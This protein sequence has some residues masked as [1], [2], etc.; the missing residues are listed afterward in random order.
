MCCLLCFLLSVITGYWYLT[1]SNRVQRMCEAYLS[2][3]TGGRVEVR[4]AALSIFEGLRLDGVSIRVDKGADAFDST[5]LEVQTVLIKYNPESI[6][7]GKL[8]ATQ[9]VAIDP[10]V[11]LV[12]NLDARRWNYQ[13]MALP[14]QPSSQPNELRIA[15]L[16][17][18]LL[19]NGQV[20]YSQIQDGVMSEL[21]TMALDGSVSPGE[22][23]GTCIFRLQSRMESE[24][25]GPVVQG[26]MV[27]A[28]GEVTAR[29]E[30]FEFGLGIKRMLPYVVRQFLEDHQL[31][32]RI[33]V[34][35]LHVQ[36]GRGGARPIF[37][38]EMN[39]NKVGMAVSP[40]EWLSRLER[41][42][43]QT[44]QGAF[45]LMRLG[46]M[47]KG[48]AFGVRG[49]GKERQVDRP[50]RLATGSKAGVVAVADASDGVY[51]NPEPRTPNPGFVDRLEGMVTPQLI[52]LEKVDGRFVFTQDGVEVHD[53][54]GWVERNSFRIS[55][56]MDGYTGDGAASLEITGDDV[57]IPHSPRYVNAMPRVVREVYEALH[58]E[59]TGR[60]WVKIDRPEPGQKPI[61]S[62]ALEVLEGQFA[63][64]LFPYPLRN[65][66]GKI[67]FGPD[68]D[69][70]ERLDIINIRGYGVKGGPNED[71]T[72]IVNGTVAPIS[73]DADVRIHVAGEHILSEPAIRSALP[74]DAR[75]ALKFLD[76]SGR[77][78]YPTFRAN[79]GADITR[80]PGPYKPFR[81]K[82]TMDLEDAAGA[83]TGFP[84]PLDHI[85]GR[86]VIGEN[87][88][89][90]E[91]WQSKKADASVTLDGSVTWGH[92]RPV[93]PD[94]TI[95]ARNAPID[96][97]L[98][99]AIAS[100]QR[101]WLERLGVSGKL[102]VDGKIFRKQSSEF[103][104]QSSANAP[105]PR[106]EAA[107]DA[108]SSSSSNDDIAVALDMRVHDGG[109]WPRDT[110]F[111]V[112]DVSGKVRLSDG[113]VTL[114]DFKGKRGDGTL[115]GG[116]SVLWKDGKPEL[117]VAGSAKDLLMEHALY[118]LLPKDAQ[119]AW[120]AVQPQGT[121]D[122]AVQYRG[123]AVVPSTQ[124]S[125]TTAAAPTTRRSYHLTLTPNKLAAT[126][127]ALPYKL[128]DLTGSIECTPDGSTLHNIMG[129]HN[130]STIAISGS[131]TSAPAATQWK[132]QLMGRNVPVD[133][134]LRKALPPA[135]S[136]LL[137][138][139][140]LK[141]T[142]AFDFT[143]LN[144]RPGETAANGSSKD[145]DLDLVGNVW[146]GGASMEIGVPVTEATGVA[147]LDTT[148][149]S[150]KLAS[151]KGSVQASSL[152]IADRPAKDF[153]TELFK[154]EKQDVMRL[155][156][157]QG[158]LAGGELAG[159]VDVAFPEQGSSRF[160]LGLVLRNS[161]VTELTG[162]KDI[163]GQVTASLSLE[164]A[165]D[166]PSTR[167]GRGDVTVSG[168]DMYH[169]PLMLGLMQVT[170]LS[171]P[172]SSPFSEG[173]AR[174]SVEGQKITFEQIELRA[175][176][177]IMQG[178]GS[179]NFDT[180]KV[181][182]TFVTDNP[183]WPKLPFVN[184]LLQ[185]A[186]HELLQI[187]VSGTVQEPKVSGSIMNTFQTTVD[188]VFRG[189]EGSDSGRRK[190]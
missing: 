21:G 90:I 18:I 190:R 48:S 164:G 119:A 60:L 168:R 49:S 27:L 140:K 74:K 112:S 141:G 180:K 176:N 181:K 66:T 25:L 22:T 39:V 158:A 95:S 144:Y 128:T 44:I 187:H 96:K 154:P 50:V 170:N 145:G 99:A 115:S 146:F 43:V 182:M 143:K 75:D 77:G 139:M 55:G 78:D 86:V 47:N 118:E 178:S 45:D 24:T 67:A 184:D 23:L 137:D 28:S 159:Q 26:Q 29:L 54:T 142:L 15:V 134:D 133:D 8:E 125:T 4:H 136:G 6:L 124:P 59:G 30:N 175:S 94:L 186:K 165:W 121:V 110:T 148:I 87:Y 69:H 72:I 17:Q 33:D 34:P 105:K 64:D 169:I 188:E 11:R 150:G 76:P 70:G 57:F 2:Q 162:E 106:A 122:L 19:R 58:P 9:I 13:R 73:G 20:Y 160:A 108:P 120:D 98:L 52:R 123:L 7:N 173:N 147:K 31:V 14:T 38:V 103:G 62:G 126:L 42:Q 157:I 41:Q 171:L 32:G 65:I 129:K 117:S 37:R 71:N 5:L 185:G 114:A 131:G 83:F 80:E 84:Y 1:D 16:P 91:H 61:V 189:G 183:N 149:R 93:T 92:G 130:G 135:L 3:L 166:D 68:P 35:T 46:G 163:H 155:D 138:S 12:E 153:Y 53:L 36:P 10:R 104:V 51:L 89:N 179:L 101:A 167:R 151:L 127:K 132:V 79:I 100:D 40:N 82:L 172:I 102:D 113:Q 107:G 109:L 174:Y 177:M 161:D 152:K 88:V 116:G 56:R 81:V 156:K 97:T 63:V 85:T 111:S